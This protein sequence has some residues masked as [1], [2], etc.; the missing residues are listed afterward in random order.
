MSSKIVQRQLQ[1]LDEP[2]AQAVAAA[3]AAA[4]VASKKAGGKKGGKKAAEKVVKL[5]SK[6][7][8]QRKRSFD[9]MREALSIEARV[10]RQRAVRG[11]A[12]RRVRRNVR[13]LSTTTAA[14][15]VTS[16]HMEDALKALQAAR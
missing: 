10:E 14:R 7:K 15:R 4:S 12:E 16:R 1:L 5:D 6:A 9:G 11:G 13:H 2:S 3:E 8:A